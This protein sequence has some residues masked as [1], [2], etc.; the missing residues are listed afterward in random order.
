MPRQPA[1][2]HAGPARRARVLPAL[3][4]ALLAVPAAVTEAKHSS[5]LGTT[6]AQYPPQQQK[7]HDE[8]GSSGSSSSPLAL[9][10]FLR[11]LVEEEGVEVRPNRPQPAAGKGGAKGVGWPLPSTAAAFTDSPVTAA[12]LPV[13]LNSSF[14]QQQRLPGRFHF[15]SLSA[16][17]AAAGPDPP[18]C[19]RAFT[20]PG[21]KARSLAVILIKWR[22][23]YYPPKEACCAGSPDP[24]CDCTW[25]GY[26]YD[27]LPPATAYERMFSDECDGFM[28]MNRVS[29]TFCWWT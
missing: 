29:W 9:P 6:P 19:T 14:Q 15:Q 2:A 21:S 13:S 17:S 18:A 11:R 28:S 27:E 7:Q 8:L 23:D 5:V 3:L 24:G 16:Y 1:H 12:G 4:L 20:T 10:D 26:K 22:R 25:S